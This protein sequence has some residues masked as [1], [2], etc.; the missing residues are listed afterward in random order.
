MSVC[1]KCVGLTLRL[2]GL[3]QESEGSSVL[4]TKLGNN[5]GGCTDN[6]SW[7]SVLVDLAK[8]GP[9]TELLLV[10]NEDKWNTLLLG[11]SLDELLVCW[12]IAALGEEDHLTVSGLESLGDLMET[13]DEG[14]VS[15]SALQ[16]FL[17]RGGGSE[18][19]GS[20]DLSGHYL[21]LAE[22][23]VIEQF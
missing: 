2:E 1:S 7:V 12:L 9:F 16:H 6:L 10:G 20:S 18:F 3:L 4:I 13:S 21:K 5:N 22:L 15:A 14:S 17:D 8:T 11:E 19:F 23:G